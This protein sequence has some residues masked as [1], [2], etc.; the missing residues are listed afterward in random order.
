MTFCMSAHCSLDAP[1]GFSQS[2][3][4]APCF[5]FTTPVCNN[6]SESADEQIFMLITPRNK[7]YRKYR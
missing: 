5:D 1:A 2:I 3:D 7:V 6:D 4:H